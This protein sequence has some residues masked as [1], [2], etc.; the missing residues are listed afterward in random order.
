MGSTTNSISRRIQIYIRNGF[1]M[2][3]RGLGDVFLFK[4][5]E[6]KFLV[7]LSLQGRGEIIRI[8]SLNYF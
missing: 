4:Q 3:I 7:T 8:A 1:R 6:A 2:G 5:S